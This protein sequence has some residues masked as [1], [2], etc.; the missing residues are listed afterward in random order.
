MCLKI[1]VCLCLRVC[2]CV[3]VRLCILQE[4]LCSCIDLNRVLDLIDTE[5][6]EI[7]FKYYSWILSDAIQLDFIFIF[8]MPNFRL[9]EIVTQSYFE[10][11]ICLKNFSAI[12]SPE[13]VSIFL[14]YFKAVVLS[15]ACKQTLLYLRSFI[16]T[17]HS[18]IYE[19]VLRRRIVNSIT[20]RWHN[21]TMLGQN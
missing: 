19:N 10:K 20:S 8:L 5:C 11:N 13:D 18:F 7:V 3:C 14:K 17:S 1:C 2:V 12:F 6:Q 16:Y 4:P 21:T 9:T 15:N